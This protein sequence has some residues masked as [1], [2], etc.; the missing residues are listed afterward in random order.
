MK[1]ISAT[2]K[3]VV[4]GLL[5]LLVSA[6]T[7]RLKG[8]FENTIVLIAYF[9]Y[10][11]GITWQML[12][13]HQENKEATFR[14]YFQQGFKTFIVVSLIMVCATW[15]F[16]KFNN[17]MIESMVNNQRDL[18]KQDKNI[19]AAEIESHLATY[20]KFILPGYT[21]AAVLSYLGIGTLISFLLGI[22]FT[23]KQQKR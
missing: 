16:L 11:A 20:R 9:V 13:F 18:L 1:R 2:Q 19:A 12:S 23:M 17:G 10:A 3:G 6:I 14:Q 4:T 7:Y 8:N 15:L 5:I 22:F 21:M